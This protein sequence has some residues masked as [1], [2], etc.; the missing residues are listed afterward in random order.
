MAFFDAIAGFFGSIRE[1]FGLARDRHALRHTPEMKA[2][3]AA[4]TDQE[5]RTEATNAVAR[6]DLDAIRK[7]AAE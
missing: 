2:N 3:A 4:K 6:R 5:I 1:V 7:Q